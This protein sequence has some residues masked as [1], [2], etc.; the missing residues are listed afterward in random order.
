[1]KMFSKII[2][3]GLAL[4]WSKTPQS[5]PP[6]LVPELSP[7]SQLTHKGV[8]GIQALLFNQKYIFHNVKKGLSFLKCVI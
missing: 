1:M 7:W 4:W 6:G 8:G 2:G 3:S 5:T